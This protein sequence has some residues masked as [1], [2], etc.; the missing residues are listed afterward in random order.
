MRSEARE[1]EGTN[2]LSLFFCL[3]PFSSHGLA[4]LF[5]VACVRMCITSLYLLFGVSALFCL[6]LPGAYDLFETSS[7][8]SGSEDHASS[9]KDLQ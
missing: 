9:Q 2:L 6:W 5:S 4:S 1:R 8:Q 3:D 7:C